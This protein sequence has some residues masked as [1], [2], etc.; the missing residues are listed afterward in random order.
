MPRRCAPGLCLHQNIWSSKRRQHQVQINLLLQSCEMLVAC[1]GITLPL[2]EMFQVDFNAC[3]WLAEQIKRRKGNQG[4]QES[5][6]G[7]HFWLK[8]MK[9][10][11][12]ISQTGLLSCWPPAVTE[13]SSTVMKAGLHKPCKQFRKQRE[14]AW[15]FLE[16]LGAFLL[17]VPRPIARTEA[18]PR[19]GLRLHAASAPTTPL[20]ARQP[21]KVSQ[22]VIR[23]KQSDPSRFPRVLKW[24][25]QARL[26]RAVAERTSVPNC[27]MRCSKASSIK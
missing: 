20:S 26:G 18:Q 8:Y 10:V 13:I 15:A 16:R 14:A 1:F 21:P 22:H 9:K 2:G 27:S 11:L 23:I 17:P 7:A 12:H 3:S 6:R 19:S 24:S 25:W 5:C 4:S